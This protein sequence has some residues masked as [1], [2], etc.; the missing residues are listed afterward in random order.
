MSFQFQFKKGN[1]ENKTK[2]RPALGKRRAVKKRNYD[3]F[4][5]KQ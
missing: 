5:C 2:T 3:N 1:E 4:L